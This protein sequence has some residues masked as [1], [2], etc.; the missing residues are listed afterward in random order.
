MRGGAEFLDEDFP[1]WAD[2]IDVDRLDLTSGCDCV[3]G[4]LF[5]GFRDGVELLGLT[6]SVS[7]VLGFNYD[8]R[9]AGWTGPLAGS[10]EAEAEEAECLRSFWVEEVAIRV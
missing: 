4:Q 2:R 8:V 7:R 3:L 6:L 10:R 9:P 1:G 5:G